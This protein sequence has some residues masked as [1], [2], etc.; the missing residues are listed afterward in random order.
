MIRII[1]KSSQYILNEALVALM[2]CGLA[3]RAAQ[4]Q[5][6]SPSW[7][8]AYE[9][10]E[11]TQDSTKQD[12]A[13]K[14]NPDPNQP[15]PPDLNKKPRRKLEIYL[16]PELGV[17]LPTNSKTR[18]RF[19]SSWIDIGL[20]IG[21]LTS[22]RASGKFS[23]DIQFLT[24]SN[25]DDFVFVGLIGVDY[26]KALLS[27]RRQRGERTQGQPEDSGQRPPAE[28]QPGEQGKP[29]APQR[30]PSNLPP[31]HQPD[32]IPYVGFSA[33]LAVGD[34]RSIEDNV[35]SGISTGAVGT[36]FVGLN[37]KNRAYIE[38]RYTQT[39]VIKG[40]VIFQD[41]ACRS[42]FERAFDIR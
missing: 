18:E 14:Q 4:A 16:G 3:G 8:P 29:K 41:L 12:P 33:D 23:P 1:R 28:M 20:S 42:E 27:G 38:A 9:T 26:R 30:R 2:F 10:A 7:A 21:G 15:A 39:T 22:P 19:G 40:F 31:Y 25:N 5:A 32:L 13:E 24:H 34:L 11:Q 17:Y 35:H 37:F 6:P 36:S